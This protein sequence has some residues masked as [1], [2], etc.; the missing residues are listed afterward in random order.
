MEF[1]NVH[2]LN[3]GWFPVAPSPN[4]STIKWLQTVLI[5]PQGTKWL[6]IG[7]HIYSLELSGWFSITVM[8]YVRNSIKEMYLGSWF[9]S[10]A[11]MDT[12][13]HCF[14]TC[15]EVEHHGRSYG[16]RGR[17]LPRGSQEA[18][19]GQA[20]LCSKAPPPGPVKLW[21]CTWIHYLLVK[22][23]PRGSLWTLPRTEK[24]VFG[25]ILTPGEGEAGESP[26][27]T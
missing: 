12:W 5:V 3:L 23:E 9:Q 7:S 21:L 15:C 11:L 20:H 8:E 24:K 25:I 1:N 19:M 17:C 13:L 4:L 26:W 10:F 22:S 14:W 18:D 6:Q 27:A 2:G 16:S